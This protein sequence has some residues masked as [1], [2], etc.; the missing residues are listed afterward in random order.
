MGLSRNDM[1]LFV[2][3]WR[4]HRYRIITIIMTT[5]IM[6][7]RQY[8]SM[9]YYMITYMILYTLLCIPA[10]PICV[11]TVYGALII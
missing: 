2:E 1:L 9:L 5:T 11:Y 4:I 7:H 6:L 8:P 3:R 10:L